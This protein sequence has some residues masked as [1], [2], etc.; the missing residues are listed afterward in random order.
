MYT[1]TTPVCDMPITLAN[2][3]PGLVLDGEIATEYSTARAGDEYSRWCNGGSSLVVEDVDIEDGGESWLE[4]L[5][6]GDT[7][8]EAIV[9]LTF[10]GRDPV[11]NRFT[12]QGKLYDR[13]Q[14]AAY[15]DAHS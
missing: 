5:I 3:Q 12:E 11:L 10:K 2:G 13:M 1:T 6:N 9:R 4:V 15:A 8:D 14:D 7:D